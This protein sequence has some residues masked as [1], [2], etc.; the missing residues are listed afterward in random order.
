MRVW[1]GLS[2]GVAALLLSG[3]VATTMAGA[4]S[5]PDPTAVILAYEAARNRRDFD[6]ALSYFADDAT[7][8]QRATTFSGKEEIRK[9][10]DGAS[11]RARSTVVADRHTSGNRVAWTER[12]AGQTGSQAGIGPGGGGPV[13]T[14]ATQNGQGL[15]AT[16]SAP[17][18]TLNV[19]A[20]VQDGKIR[21]VAYLSP[22]QA[23]RIDPALEGRAQLPA[24][25]GLG[26]VA[27][28]VLTVLMVASMG[29]RGAGP[30]TSTLRGRMLRDLRGWNAARQAP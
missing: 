10:L 24:T 25:A 12:S 17:T 13:S 23:A 16:G 3:L 1:V 29:L 20:V 2:F 19:E 30:G 5:G 9:F 6:T 14:V 7:V 18:F 21:S 11:T 4:Q 28:L 8:S 26:A 22:N 15:S 27:I